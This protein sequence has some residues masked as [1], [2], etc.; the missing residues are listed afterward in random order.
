MEK[1]QQENSDLH[2]K[3]SESVQVLEQA[4]IEHDKLQ[5]IIS[6][7]ES[8]K[9]KNEQ[10]TKEQKLQLKN[11]FQTLEEQKS[12]IEHLNQDNLKLQSELF[13]KE[14]NGSEESTSTQCLKIIPKKSYLRIS[15]I[16][17]FVLT[18]LEN[19]NFLKSWFSKIFF[20]F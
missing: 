7:L 10:V 6:E 1:Y 14:S 12:E 15:K 13:A 18:S 2:R 11:F 4:N 9:E 17:I 5:A 3:L 19:L 16:V 8:D 20:F